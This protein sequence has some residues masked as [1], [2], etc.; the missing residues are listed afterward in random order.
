MTARGMDNS[1]EERHRLYSRF[2]D[3]HAACH[4]FPRQPQQSGTNRL[5]NVNVRTDLHS[6]V[7]LHLHVT[8]DHKCCQARGARGT[9]L[10]SPTNLNDVLRGQG[11]C[12]RSTP[13]LQNPSASSASSASS[14]PPTTRAPPSLRL[15]GRSSRTSYASSTIS[16]GSGVGYILSRRMRRT[17]ATW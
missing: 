7:H 14:L 16:T 10:R 3:V 4:R 2:R 11:L 5:R 17:C 12:G 9:P 1:H 15:I 6:C 13:P 8:R